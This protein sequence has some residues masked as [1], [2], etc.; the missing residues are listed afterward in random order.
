MTE[1][2]RRTK[3]QEEIIVESRCLTRQE[4][5]LWKGGMTSLLLKQKTKKQKKGVI[6]IELVR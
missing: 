6:F 4:V 5:Q 2:D 1:A 3:V